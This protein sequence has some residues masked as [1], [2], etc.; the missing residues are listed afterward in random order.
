MLDEEL[1]DMIAESIY[2]DLTDSDEPGAKN[3]PFSRLQKTGKDYY[4]HMAYNIINIFD[5]WCNCELDSEELE[6]DDFEVG[7]LDDD[8]DTEDEEW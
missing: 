3:V 2:R 4:K 6:E 8:N 7:G 1:V 5:D